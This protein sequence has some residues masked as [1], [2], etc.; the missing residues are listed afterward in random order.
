MAKKEIQ[1]GLTV[2]KADNFSEWYT[3]V[4]QKAD[5]AD[6]SPVSGCIIFKPYSYA[7]WEKIKAS[8]DTKIKAMDVQNAYFPLFIPE[9]LLNKEKEHVEGFSP[10]VAWV[11]HAGKSKLDQRLAV[12][13][14]SET[15]MYDAY[16]KWIR[17][18][19]D[20]P[21]KLNQWNNVVRWEFKHCVPFLRTREFL[22]NEGHTCFAT[23][24]EA[25][26]ECM[27]IVSM[28]ETVLK[29]DLALHSIVGK[30]TEKEK[31]AG[32]DYT[33]STELFMP[34]GKAIQGPDSH[35][36]GQNFAKAF[37]I[38]FLDKN[39][40]RQYVWQ[41]TWAIS[42]RVI[43]ILIYAHGDDKGIVLPP[44]IAPNKA[45][46]I[47]ILFKQTQDKVLKKA[48]E[49][50]KTLKKYDVVVDDRTYYTP[51]WKYNEWEL[52]GVPLRIE[53]GPKDL[54]KK[55][56]VVVQRDTGKK[57]IVKETALGKTVDVLL[58]EMQNNLYKRSKAVFDK[59]LVPAKNMTELKKAIKS[60]QFIR[61]SWC[62]QVACEEKIKD[63]TD[64]AKILNLPFPQPKNHDVCVCCGNVGKHLAHI[65]KSY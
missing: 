41:N 53:I 1:Q 57:H 34:N 59:K 44:N 13:P 51:G 9:D 12:R 21:L 18:W 8:V 42:T 37:D 45:V 49:L 4:I 35:H 52:K 38:T 23:K 47:P 39:E 14:T 63:Q 65:A 64:G 7:I 5:L 43:G 25:D 30:K 27:D 2:K 16:S 46:I 15:I 19:R 36:D 62:G 60:K 3:Q 28:Y 40:K 48:K 54:E 11:T 24:A 20:L 26:K 17:S 32:A 31:F 56:V 6:Y 55:Q 10:E 29:D 61:A 58:K 50:A 33:L 22:W